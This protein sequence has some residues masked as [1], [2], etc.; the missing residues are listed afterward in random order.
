MNTPF[1]VYRSEGSKRIVEPEHPRFEKNKMKKEE[2]PMKYHKRLP[3]LKALCNHEP[4]FDYVG[5]VKTA[6]VDGCFV[7]SINIDAYICSFC[8]KAKLFGLFKSKATC[9]QLDKIVQVNG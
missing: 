6:V 7:I 1:L 8:G 5:T 2:K 3:W 4:G 9:F